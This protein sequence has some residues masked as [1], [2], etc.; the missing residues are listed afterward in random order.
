MNREK[1]VNYG[2]GARLTRTD[3]LT[4]RI[5]P[6]L[7][8]LLEIAAR[9]ERR[10]KSSFAESVLEEAVGRVLDQVGISKLRCETKG[11]LAALLW[12]PEPWCRLQILAERFPDAMT[13]E[14]QE[15]WTFLKEVDV[16]WVDATTRERRLDALLLRDIWPVVQ[17]VIAGH[18]SVTDLIA[19]AKRIKALH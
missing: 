8:Y 2:R 6:R 5:D 1:P 15:I 18:L 14:D 16:F 3:V 9:L 11:E 13:V 12:H 7:N 17:A 4:V 19:E 10:T